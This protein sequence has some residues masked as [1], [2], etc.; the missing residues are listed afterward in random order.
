MY[1]H[2]TMSEYC[3]TR[4]EYNQI[5]RK[6]RK[7]SQLTQKLFNLTQLE[8]MLEAKLKFTPKVEQKV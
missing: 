8:E 1:V 7:V 3:K 6:A 4:D 5:T 2:D